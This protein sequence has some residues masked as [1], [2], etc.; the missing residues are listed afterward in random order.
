GRLR[1]NR[2]RR[3]PDRPC[4]PRE[5]RSKLRPP[6]R[7]A[8]RRRSGI[9][10][11]I[12]HTWLPPLIKRLRNF[13]PGADQIRQQRVLEQLPLPVGEEAATLKGERGLWMLLHG[14]AHN[15]GKQAQYG[16]FV[17]VQRLLERA[18]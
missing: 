17:G 2:C 4:R 3:R 16:R 7:R 1:E 5:P 12:R 10:A 18:A 8:P 13:T 9:P 14:G 11:V 15:R 6:R